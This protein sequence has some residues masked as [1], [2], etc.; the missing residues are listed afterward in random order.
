[1]A[2]N[3]EIMSR[4]E[5]TEPLRLVGTEKVTN[6]EIEQTIKIVNELLKAKKKD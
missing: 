5:Q 6:E 1:L 2:S 3:K 4:I